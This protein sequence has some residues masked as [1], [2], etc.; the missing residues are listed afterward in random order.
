MKLT[1]SGPPPKTRDPAPRAATSVR[2]PYPVAAFGM[3]EE[4]P[5]A[6]VSFA[7]SH[8]PTIVP[9]NQQFECAS[10]FT[11]KSLNSSR[12]PWWRFFVSVQRRPGMTADCAKP[13]AGVDVE[14]TYRIAAVD[15]H[16]GKKRTFAV[17]A[18]IKTRTSNPDSYLR[19]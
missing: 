9:C 14:R 3:V 6:V 2:A 15:A 12:K 19:W 5:A 11:L 4:E 1:L 17:Q 16:M 8:F 7:L 18:P 10:N 13:A